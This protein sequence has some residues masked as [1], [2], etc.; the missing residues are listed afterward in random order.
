MT[1]KVIIYSLRTAHSVEDIP[2]TMT[3]GDLIGFLE[4]C[5]P[6]APVYVS[7]FDGHL[8]SPILNDDGYIQE[9]GDETDND[10]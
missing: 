1:K 6:N 3:V 7:G 10:N 8:F 2:Q 4:W 5:D 9:V